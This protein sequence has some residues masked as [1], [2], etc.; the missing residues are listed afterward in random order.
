M[1]CNNILHI[2]SKGDTSVMDFIDDIQGR[3]SLRYNVKSLGI[4]ELVEQA[5]WKILQEE[6]KL[7]LEGTGSLKSVPWCWNFRV[8]GKGG[9]PENGT[10]SVT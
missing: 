1:L 7:L 6:R 5:C 10:V 3:E 9:S 8:P 2:L 4:C